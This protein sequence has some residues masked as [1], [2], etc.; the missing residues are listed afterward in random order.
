MGRTFAFVDESGNHDLD[1]SKS[2]NSAFF[3]VCSVIVAEKDL[4]QAYELA[5]A[6]RA[7]NFQTGEIKSSNLRVK[8]SDRRKRIL[9]E[10]AETAWYFNILRV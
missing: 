6:V 3:V 2:G 5:E 8:D 9:L 4:Q 10:L 1:T 7:R